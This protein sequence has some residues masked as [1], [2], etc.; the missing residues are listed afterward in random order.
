[1]NC[2]FRYK[3]CNCMKARLEGRPYHCLW[4]LE[5]AQELPGEPKASHTFN[6]PSPL[7]QNVSDINALEEAHDH[8][9]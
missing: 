5:E 2:F 7:F 8:V 3:H 4:A 1:M 6:T 9:R